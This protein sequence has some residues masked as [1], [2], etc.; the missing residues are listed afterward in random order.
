MARRKVRLNV[1]EAQ[2]KY[3][4]ALIAGDA[5]K[6]AQVVANLA[7]SKMALASIYTDVLAPSMVSVGEWWCQS[8]INVAQEH[9]ATQI[10]LAQMEKL[11][12]MQSLPRPL[13]Y[14]IMVACVEGELHF[15][16]ARMAADLFQLEGWSVDFLG[17]DVPTRALIDISAARRVDLLCVSITMETNFPALTLLLESLRTFPDR[18]KLIIGGR[19]NGNKGGWRSDADELETASTIVEGLKIARKLLKPNQPVV[20]LSDYLKE[21][22]QHIRALRLKMGWTQAQLAQAT[23][24]TRAYLVSVE[25]GRQNVSI[26]VVVRIAN[27]LNVPPDQLISRNDF[28]GEQ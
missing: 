28:I 5:D 9:L 25:A 24:L 4:Q 17:P 10:T 3:L 15:I 8:R 16:G 18:P 7:A 2:K 13:P 1:K 14:A 21:L 6:A 23:K 26:D 19:V 20:V 12:S 11:R 22:G 27:A